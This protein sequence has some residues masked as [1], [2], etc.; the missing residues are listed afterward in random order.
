MARPPHI[1]LHVRTQAR[2][3]T[4]A[5]LVDSV[6][7]EHAAGR[8][9]AGS[10]LPPVRVLE[11]QYG[12]SKNTAQVAYD[13]LVARGIAVTR[14]REGVFIADAA[15]AAAVEPPVLIPP[16]PR[17]RPP[18]VLGTGAPRGGLAMGNVFIDPDLLPTEKLAECVR[19][20]LRQPGLANLYDAQGHPPLRRAIAARLTARGIDVDPDTVIVTTGSQQALD[21]VARAL[22]IRRVAIET[23]VYAYAKL[24]FESLNLPV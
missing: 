17:L 2:R 19:S 4:A 11:Q 13:E 14:E 16:L 5:D 20:V 8:L 24:L 23:P 22:E 18:P 6:V 10:R 12:L 9:P 21:L 1:A 15:T 7:R 3:V